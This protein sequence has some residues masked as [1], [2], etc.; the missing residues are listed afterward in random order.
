MASLTGALKVR[1]YHIVEWKVPL[2]EPGIYGTYKNVG[3]AINMSERRHGGG[4][5]VTR[6]R[7][8]KY[9][10][11]LHEN[12]AGLKVRWRKKGVEKI[13]IMSG[14]SRGIHDMADGELRARTLETDVGGEN[15]CTCVVCACM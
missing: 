7:I 11:C 9:V 10:T 6:G 15:R 3:H 1:L 4:W 12:K 2:K 13:P 14:I 8:Q 5:Y